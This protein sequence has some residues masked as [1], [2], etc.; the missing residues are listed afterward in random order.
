MTKKKKIP[1]S[2]LKNLKLELDAIKL[3]K[4]IEE[5]KV[6][7][8]GRPTYVDAG[9]TV[10]IPFK[11]GEIE[12]LGR[13][14]VYRRALRLY[15]SNQLAR[16]IIN[17][18]SSSLFRNPP[19]FQGDKELVS[20]ANELIENSQ[21]DWHEWGNEF[22]LFGNVFLRIFGS[23]ENS[24]VRSLPPINLDIDV[25]EEDAKSVLQYVLFK[26]TDDEELVLPEDVVSIKTNS[27]SNQV[28]G[29]SELRHIFYWLDVLD[30]LWEKGWIRTAQYFGS[31]VVAIEGI[32]ANA[33]ANIETEI[34][35]KGWKP[36]KVLVL[37][38]STERE[39][40]QAKVLNFGEGFEM[41]NLVD[42]VF[43]Y[44]VVA[45]GIPQSLLMESDASRGVAMFSQ[46]SFEYKI[47]SAQS[48]WS[49]GL[50][51]LMVRHFKR[52]GLVEKEEKLNSV[53][54]KVGWL[55]VFQR[56]EKDLL[57]GLGELVTLNVISKQT[58]REKL[59]IDH[60]EEQK[61]INQEKEDEPNQIAPQAGVPAPAKGLAPKSKVQTVSPPV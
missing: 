34:T 44:I 25:E 41:E 52:S 36:G 18:L 28:F 8:F 38:G 56:E 30:S 1:Q 23:G 14:D 53:N 4:E 39:R 32:P 31:P 46:P 13:K 45:T 17:I 22:F 10:K 54:F 7:K 6:A 16:P 59:N 19:D 50:K 55:P 40:P 42:R 61:R 5:I 29:E 47:Q 2:E 37:P 24:I 48:K 20:S 60:S 12:D 51:D 33:Q 15:Y 58:A 3:Q 21:V 43:R 9:D 57:K 35:S 11:K 49:V 26:S 27:V